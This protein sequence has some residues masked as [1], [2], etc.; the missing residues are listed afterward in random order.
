M[1]IANRTVVGNMPPRERSG[2]IID[3][4]KFVENDP[5]YIQ[6]YFPCS[7]TEVSGKLSISKKICADY[8]KYDPYMKELEKRKWIQWDMRL[9]KWNI[10]KWIQGKDPVYDKLTALKRL[11][12]DETLKDQYGIQDEWKSFNEIKDKIK[13]AEIKQKIPYYFDLKRL[14]SLPEERTLLPKPLIYPDTLISSKRR[15]STGKRLERKRKRS[16]IGDTPLSSDH[17]T[18]DHE[19]ERQCAVAHK[20]VKGQRVLSPA[21]PCSDDEMENDIQ[22]IGT[23]SQTS[24]IA[25]NSSSTSRT[26]APNPRSAE[27]WY[28]AQDV[29]N[30]SKSGIAPRRMTEVGSDSTSTSGSDASSTSVMDEGSPSSKQI[31]IQ[32]ARMK[33]NDTAQSH[34][35][36]NRVQTC[37]QSTSPK[38]H[39]QPSNRSL[40]PERKSGNPNLEI[41]NQSHPILGR[42]TM[43]PGPEQKP[44]DPVARAWTKIK[45]ENVLDPVFLESTT[46]YSLYSY[47]SNSRMEFSKYR[48]DVLKWSKLHPEC[49]THLHSR[50]RLEMAV[51]AFRRRVDANPLSH[52]L[53]KMYRIFVPP[54][55]LDDAVARAFVASLKQAGA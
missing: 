55:Y 39:S 14:C 17:G 25:P 8:M 20:R 6:T 52:E 28:M 26:P 3:L 19:N 49:E 13:R 23:V 35:E 37:F 46:T 36:A 7:F 27:A 31:T 5:L 50:A 53:L 48:P 44:T 24:K 22:Y 40:G 29:R 34:S 54:G 18:T 51:E 47:S 41:Q 42:T 12:L 45:G 11:C 33:I 32:S 2:R 21:L 9:D 43:G 4:I 30:R 15:I 16:R 10:E 38:K 1:Y